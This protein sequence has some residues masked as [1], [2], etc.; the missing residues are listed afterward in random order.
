M[1]AV[2]TAIIAA[3]EALALALVGVVVIAVPA[4][5]LWWLGFGLAAEPQELA[6]MI[7]GVWLLTHFV[8]LTFTIDADAA[9]GLGLSPEPLGFTLS[10][11]PLGLTLLTLWRA[12]HA[13][14]RFADRGGH[15]YWGVIGGTL[16]FGI[17][18]S[19]IASVAGPV[20]DRSPVWAAMPPALCYIVAASL[21]FVVRAALSEQEWW[22]ALVR[23]TQRRLE[24][25][26]GLWAAALPTRCAEAVRLAAALLAAVLGLAGL[27]LACALVFGYVG[28][29]TLSEGLQLD[30]LGLFVVFLVSL[31]LLPVLL[32]W[33]VAW[34]SGAGFAIGAGTSVTPFDTL[35]G[36]LPAFPLFGA[37]PHDWGWAGGIAPALVVLIGAC[38]G[39]YA[40]GRSAL[41]HSSLAASVVVPVS[42]AVLCGLAFV[43]CATAASG[44]LGP[45]RL[46]TVGVA[47]WRT[48]MW[49][50]LELAIGV[51]PGILASR[52]DLDRMRRSDG[53]PHLGATS[54]TVVTT[55]WSPGAT[56]RATT[57]EEL[58]AAAAADA[59]TDSEEALLRAFSWSDM[60]PD[61]PTDADGT[62]D[63]N[64]DDWHSARDSD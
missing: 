46:D 11:V 53:R 39:V 14:W 32:V 23:V 44:S 36:P 51:V 6:S 40:G 62:P 10:L 64:H 60:V 4:V 55:A 26:H 42:A 38:V 21:C 34:L 12:G 18:A 5:L 13:G 41:R 57:A 63:V 15:G 56:A 25:M 49:V 59:G 17:A 47:P 2:L 27:A 30:G 29:V 58:V 7:S 16:G 22:R 28:V 20:L 31:A 52:L 50:T 37:I 45:G 24:P 8:P 33:A 1:K 3:I 54:A 19:A 35:L 61:D 9:L 48:G 43:L